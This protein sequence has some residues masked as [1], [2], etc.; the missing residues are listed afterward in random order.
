MEKTASRLVTIG[1]ISGVYGVHGW[2]KVYSYT[3]PR[4]AILDYSPWRI[5]REKRWESV[6]VLDGRRQGKTVVAQLEG[7]TDRDA[8]RA[9][10]GAEVAVDRGQLGEAEPGKYFWAD[11]IGLEVVNREGVGLGRVDH[12]METGANDVLVVQ[13]ERERLIPFV[14]EHY[15]VEVDLEAGRITVDWSP[16]D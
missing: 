1:R 13:G 6:S 15:I 5:R 16:E 2:V 14:P 8:V 10:T 12:L 9:L 4:E 11:L 3:V 7:W